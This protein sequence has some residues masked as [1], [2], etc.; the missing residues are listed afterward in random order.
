MSGSADFLT[1]AISETNPLTKEFN[2]IAMEM[3]GQEI[4]PIELD[5]E[6]IVSNTG[7]IFW[8]IGFVTAVDGQIQRKYSNSSGPFVV[9]GSTRLKDNNIKR[10]KSILE[11]KST[12]PQSFFENERIKFAILKINKVDS[13]YMN[14][15]RNGEAEMN[16]HF[17]SVYVSGMPLYKN[18]INLRSKDYRWINYWNWICKN[19][20]YDEKKKKYI[21]L[22]N[23][24]EKNLYLI[25]YRHNFK[26]ES[27]YWIAGMHW[28]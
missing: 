24:K 20:G 5:K 6:E 7:E 25:L 23:Q 26:T 14:S 16:K 4:V 8:D 17:L 19:D 13:I 11:A 28:L 3:K 18:P 21:R 27:H 10:L 15:E 9:S 2:V 22:F 1:L 12:F